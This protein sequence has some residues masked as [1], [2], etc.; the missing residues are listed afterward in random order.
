MTGFGDSMHIESELKAQKFVVN[1]HRDAVQDLWSALREPPLDA[2][3]CL[4]IKTLFVIISIDQGGGIMDKRH[5]LLCVLIIC[6][7]VF[8][9]K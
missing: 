6:G 1:L 5:A 4:S 2:V 7:R 9:A 3:L 8:N